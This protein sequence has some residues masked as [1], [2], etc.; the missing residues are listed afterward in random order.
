MTDIEKKNQ[1]PWLYPLI[2]IGFLILNFLPV[3]AEKPFL[4]QNTQDVILNLLM[5][6]D[7]PFRAFAPIFHL[8]TL[9]LAGLILW[10]PGR[11]GR[12]AAAYIGINYLVLVL[13]CGMGTTEK[14]GFVVMTGS[15]ALYAILGI[16]WLIVAVRNELQAAFRK[17]NLVEMGLLLLTLLA[18]WAP[19]TIINGAVV[20]S[21]NPALLLTAPD[22]G[23]TFCF[24]TPVFLMGLILCYPKVNGFA[25]RITAINGVIYGL[26]NMMHWFY[27]ERMWMGALH[28]PLLL[29]SLY[30]LVYPRLY[31]AAQK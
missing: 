13:T 23:M 5:V 1:K 2:F 18:F 22:F 15:V 10:K 9:L 6:A 12:L 8:A 20:P 27:P 7:V 3:Y 4:P 30:A 14:Y 28:L 21:F 19:Y 25:F 24:T 17:L 11:W 26:L 31:A 29:I 16:T